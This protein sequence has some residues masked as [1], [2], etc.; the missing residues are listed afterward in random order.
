[1]VDI[2]SGLEHWEKNSCP[3]EILSLSHVRQHSSLLPSHIPYSQTHC[4]TTCHTY[5]RELFAARPCNICLSLLITQ[6]HKRWKWA[7][8]SSP[9]IDPSLLNHVSQCHIPMPLD[10]LQ[11]WWFHWC[12]GTV[13]HQVYA[14]TH[15]DTA[16]ECTVDGN[17]NY[18]RT[19][20]KIIVSVVS[21]ITSSLISHKQY[22]DKEIVC[23]VTTNLVKT[24]GY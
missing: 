4:T 15:T 22:P 8:R 3:T 10:H 17:K 23:S 20:C 6:S 21:V 7:L 9:T 2:Q 14:C 1:M 13:F 11:G 24:H 5:N 19:N 12:L 16:T 18:Q